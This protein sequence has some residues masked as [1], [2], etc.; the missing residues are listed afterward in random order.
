M[1]TKTPNLF[2]LVTMP[3]NSLWAVP[4]TVV[5]ESRALYYA[6]IDTGDTEGVEF[7]KVFKEEVEFALNDNFELIDWAENNMD[8]DDVKT[9]AFR[10]ETKPKEVDYQTGWIQGEKTI[11]SLEGIKAL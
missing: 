7:D 8:W 6:R 11:S 9:D 3:D 5:A 2:I 4:A 1:D 10:V